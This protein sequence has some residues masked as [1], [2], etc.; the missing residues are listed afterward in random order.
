MTTADAVRDGADGS[1]L[2]HW[3]CL[4]SMRFVFALAFAIILAG[5]AGGAASAQPVEVQ[6][7]ITDTSTQSPLPQVTVVVQNDGRDWGTTTD[8]TGQFRLQVPPGSY[9]L[10]ASAVGYEAHVRSITLEETA[11]RSLRFSLAPSRYELSEIVVQED[12]VQRGGVPSTVQRVPPASI[13]RQG[14]ADVSELAP[15]LPATHVQTNSR[16]Q[17][18]LYFRNAGDRQVGQF[19]D[20]AL[21][22]V[23]WDNRVDISLIPASVVDEMTVTKGVPSVRYGA[24]VLGGAVNVQSRTLDTLGRRTEVRGELGTA[25]TRQTAVTHLGRTAHWDY[26]AAVQYGDRGDQPLAR[27]A[28]LENNQP[29]ADRRVNTDRQRWSGFGRVGRRFEDG[30][31]V[32]LSV[33]HVDATQGVAPEG[34]VPDAQTRYWRYPRWQKSLVLLSGQSEFGETTSVRGAVWGSRFAQDIAQ[35]QSIAYDTRTEVQK[36]RDLTAGLRL[37]GTQDVSVGTLTLALNALTTRHRQTNVPFSGGTAGPDSSTSYRQHILSTGIEYEVALHSR[38]TAT[39]GLNLDHTTL[40][41]TG[42]FPPRDPFSA[43]GGTAGLRVD[44]GDGWTVRAVGGRK[45]RFP[46]MREL[47]GAALGKFVPNPSLSPVTAWIGEVGAEYRAENL[48]V[49]GTAFL[50]RVYDTIDKRTFQTGPNAGKEQRINLPGARIYGLET[51][52]RWQSSS[53]LTLDGS[54]TWSRPRSLMNTGRRKL[55][56]KPGLLGTG[57]ATLALPGGVSLMG[58]ARYTGNVYARNEQNTFVALPEALILDA[59]ISY[60]LSGLPRLTDGEVYVR[61]DNLADEA[62]FVG[63]GLPG[64]GRTIRAGIEI[65]F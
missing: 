34:N 30:H 40:P 21:L 7:T 17:T 22:N 8:S 62:R 6:G 35:Y 47:F 38:V 53:L 28:N 9:R 58:Q 14:A 32:G 10:R 15:L 1:L 56:E 64:P 23:P 20:G 31:K 45:S 55:D 39:A 57:T 37:I 19:F 29:H 61:V 41:G 52:A 4:Q 2:V 42:P 65:A 46:T 16:G 13:Q 43:W 59:R 36:D 49:E 60:G 24:N 25:A 5:G 33:L 50:N 63:L 54:L 26:T 44:A 48:T 12:R 51:S 27:N 11:S 3:L 18:I